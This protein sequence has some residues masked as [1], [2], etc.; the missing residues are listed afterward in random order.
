MVLSQLKI[1]VFSENQGSK[2]T[3]SVNKRITQYH[4]LQPAESSCEA[5]FLNQ[6][7]IVILEWVIFLLCGLSYDGKIFS[8][9][10]RVF[11][12][13]ASSTIFSAVIRKM[14]PERREMAPCWE[15]LL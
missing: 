4:R 10:S 9:I 14:S 2:N 7:I 12:L 5:G 13:D 15:A 6:G 11:L 3:F 8:R 1:W